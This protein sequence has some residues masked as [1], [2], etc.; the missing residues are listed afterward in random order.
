MEHYDAVVVGAGQ[1]GLAV[2]HELGAAG[3]E[4]VVL[5]RGR[6]GQSWRQ[7]W[8]SF[9]LVTPNWTVRLPGL[10]YDG[11][12]PD[13]FMPRDEIVGTLVNYAG[14]FRAPVRENVDVAAVES[15]SDGGFIL[16]ASSGDVRSRVL[17]LATGAFQRAHRPESAAALP[18]GL[19]QMDVESYRNERVLPPGSVL[20]IGSGQSGAQIS[21]ELREAGRKVVLSCGKAAWVP[22]RLGGRDIVWWLHEAGFFDQTVDALP[23]PQARLAAN[24]LA[25]GH[26]GGRDLNLRTLQSM[27]VTLTGRFLG[28]RDG[29]ARFA[30]DL[31]ESLAWGDQRHRELMGLIKGRAQELGIALQ[32]DEPGAFVQEAPESIDLSGFGIVI[33]AGGFRPAYG[34]WLPWPSA[35]D[36]LGFPIQREGASTVVPGLFFAGVHFLRKRKSSLLLGV[37]EDAA[38]VTR[39]IAAAV[40]SSA[41]RSF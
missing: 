12:D 10:P 25:T 8:D 24:P 35:F 18:S 37:G 21:E 1:A 39:H 34:S 20:I 41:Q 9:C 16:R 7:R 13:G 15:P 6:I 27:G 11:P 30:P 23:T 33:F 3:I 22:R 14:G 29:R 4:H 31:G 19:P 26:G 2:S 5:E 40:A 32:I 36:G 38:I 17:V 28:M